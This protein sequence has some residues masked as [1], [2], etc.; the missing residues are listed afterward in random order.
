MLIGQ[1]VLAG[2]TLNYYNNCDSAGVLSSLHVL[3]S[4][5]PKDVI[6][7]VLKLYE[8]LFSSTASVQ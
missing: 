2:K 6:V 5:E 7:T 8:E 4:L 3:N 1:D